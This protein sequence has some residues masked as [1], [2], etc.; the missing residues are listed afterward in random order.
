MSVPR[1]SPYL[2]FDGNCKEA[3]EFYQSILG[4]KLD[5]S[6]FGEGMPGQDTE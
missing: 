4:G 6:T 5:L 3:M 2:Q 1:L